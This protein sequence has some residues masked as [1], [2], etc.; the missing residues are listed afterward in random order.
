MVGSRGA[1]DPERMQAAVAKLERA[2]EGSRTLVCAAASGGG[3][4]VRGA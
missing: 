4:P 3:G 2:S 1:Y